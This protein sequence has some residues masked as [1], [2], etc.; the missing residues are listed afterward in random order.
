MAPKDEVL[1]GVNKLRTTL[2]IV[3]LLALLVVA[4]RSCC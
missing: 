1:A 3:G 2:I 4:A